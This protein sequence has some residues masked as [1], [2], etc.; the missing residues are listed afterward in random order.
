MKLDIFRLAASRSFLA[1]KLDLD[2]ESVEISATDD[3]SM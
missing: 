1:E 2:G 3:D